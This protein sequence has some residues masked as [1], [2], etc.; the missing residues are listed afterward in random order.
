MGSRTLLSKLMGLAE[1]I[2]PMLNTQSGISELF[3]L[4]KKYS[5]TRFDYFPFIIQNWLVRTK[6]HHNPRLCDQKFLFCFKNLIFFSIFT[7]ISI[8]KIHLEW[9]GVS[10]PKVG[11]WL[12]RRGSVWRL[13]ICVRNTDTDPKVAFGWFILIFKWRKGLKHSRASRPARKLK[14]LHL[15]LWNVMPFFLS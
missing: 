8:I 13:F 12:E 7:K 10:T 6:E 2:E 1:R 15:L 14:V 5:N 4:P 3:S 9:H 11:N